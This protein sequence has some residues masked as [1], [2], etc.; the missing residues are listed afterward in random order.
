MACSRVPP[1]PFT[2]PE[3]SVAAPSEW[4]P[5]QRELLRD[6]LLSW[7]VRS[8]RPLP[9]RV[10]RTPYR[11][12]ISEIMLQQTR[13]EAV[14]PYFN[15]FVERFGSVR[16]LAEASEPEVLKYWAGLGYYSRARNIHRA[17]RAIMAEHGGQVP[18]QLRDLQQ[19]PGIGP[20]TAGAIA[21][22]A[23]GVEIA[24]VD[25]NVM[26]VLSRLLRIKGDP[27]SGEANARLRRAAADLVRGPDPGSLNEALMEL[28]A[29]VCGPEVPR[30]ESCPVSDWCTAH[31][32]G[33]Q[34]R[35]PE[36][37]PGPAIESRSHAAVVVEVDGRVLLHDRRGTTVWKGLWAFPTDFPDSPHSGDPEDAARAICDRIGSAGDLQPVGSIRHG[38]MNWKID[39]H[40][41]YVEGTDGMMTTLTSDGGWQWAPVESLIDLALPSPHRRISGM[42]LKRSRPEPE[43]PLV[44]ALRAG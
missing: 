23:Y 38:V 9:W 29:T 34:S 27:R 16:E 18:C 5:E 35:Y 37:A 36:R 28:G 14:C 2:G 17:A 6:A 7:F 8:A 22:I 26:R 25:G 33:D 40:V 15:R 20:Y 41:Y 13:V 24:A 4:G 11:S 43:S 3:P 42:I 10:E 32:A 21:S 19:L 30:C 12:W 39:L 1:H 31:F 44:V